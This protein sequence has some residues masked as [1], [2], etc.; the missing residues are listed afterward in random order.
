LKGGEFQDASYGK[1]YVTAV[2]KVTMKV[3]MFPNV[4]ASLD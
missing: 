3:E 4:D 1:K 2:L